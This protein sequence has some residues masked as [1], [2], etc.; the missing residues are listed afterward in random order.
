VRGSRGEGSRDASRRGRTVSGNRVSGAIPR[1]FPP[2]RR[3]RPVCARR[4]PSPAQKSAWLV[5]RRRRARRYAPDA[6][7]PR[8]RPARARTGAAIVLRRSSS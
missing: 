3:A 1:V 6:G 2:G 5:C 7:R 8:G 4:V